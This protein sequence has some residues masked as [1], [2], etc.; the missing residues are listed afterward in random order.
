VDGVHHVFPFSAID[1]VSNHMKGF[2]HHVADVSAAYRADVDLAKAAMFAAYDDFASSPDWGDGGV[3][4]FEWFGVAQLADSG[5][6]LR[7]RLKT[8]PASIGRPAA[9]TPSS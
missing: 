8:S 7:A 9:P 2:R 3:S 6:Q 1:A 4:G 5:V